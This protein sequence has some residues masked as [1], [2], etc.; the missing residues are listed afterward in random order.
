MPDLTIPVLFLIHGFVYVCMA[1]FAH[2]IGLDPNAAWGRSRFFLFLLGTI[3]ILVSALSIYFRK[4]KDNF[5]I[6][7]IESGTA[8]LLFSLGH[9]W[10]IVFLI[11][12]WFITYGNWNT[13]NRSSNYYDQLANSFHNGKINIDIEPGK[14]FLAVSDPYNP[15]VR[16]TF[17][18][19]IWDMSLYGG[20]FYLYWGP[21]PALL[22][23]PI[24]FFSDKQIT[25]SYLVF[26]FFAGL[27]IF[28]S[29]IILKL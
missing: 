16:P 19:D 10:L 13:W 11:Y 8:K 22:I 1:V 15:A 27:L 18:S 3:L 26:F 17:N 28:N 4:R 25:D 29:L 20:K 21:L 9:I 5:F 2:E 24:K 12:I 7:A 6:S 23:T 14:A